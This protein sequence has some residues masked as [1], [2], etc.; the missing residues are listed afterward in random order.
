M[1]K[2]LLCLLLITSCA[3]SSLKEGVYKLEG[4]N[5]GSHNINYRGEV[6]IESKGSNYELTWLIGSSRSQSQYGIGILAGNVLS[7]S[8][9]D[10]SSS[11]FSGVVSYVI[12]SDWEIEGKWAQKGS[13]TYGVEKLTFLREF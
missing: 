12:I 7:V 8:F 9:Y 11:N 1:Q 6:W 5:Q 3:Y 13:G 4:Y 10:L 2:L